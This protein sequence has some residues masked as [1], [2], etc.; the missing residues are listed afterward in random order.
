MNQLTVG[1][2]PVLPFDVQESLNQLRINLGFSGAEIKTIMVTSSTP[3]EG[4]SFV[5]IN[6]WKMMASVGNRVLLID[7]DLRN[8]DMR[9]KYRFQNENGILG[10]EHYLSGK[11]E[12]FDSIYETNYQNGYIIPVSTNIVDP[13]TLLESARFKIMIDQCKTRFDYII[14]DTPP[15]GSVADALNIAKHCD[16]TLLV[17]RS[18][19]VPK[20]IVNDSV[21]LLR[22]TEVPLLGV[23]LNRVDTSKRGS[24]YGYYYR[25]GYYSNYGYGN[26]NSDKKKPR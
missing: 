26:G 13:T 4:K 20:K 7:T 1:S 10:V 19:E 3:N 2:M 23:V 11:I 16:G 24:N 15:L 18:G 6:L 9:T 17:I 25:Y 22:R 21:S 14:V 5:A 12:L 8:S